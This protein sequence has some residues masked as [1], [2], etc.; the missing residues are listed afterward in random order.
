MN[1][2]QCW[3]LEDIK[4]IESQVTHDSK[5]SASVAELFAKVEKVRDLPPSKKLT[6]KR[7]LENV[8]CH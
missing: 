5:I 6:A 3:I 7:I 1:A 2:A 8:I 4:N